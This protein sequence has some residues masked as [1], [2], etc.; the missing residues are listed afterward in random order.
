[1]TATEAQQALALLDRMDPARRSA[2]LRFMEFLLLEPAS[3]AAAAAPPD[4]ELVTEEDR[5]RLRNGH[6]WF[7]GRG[8]K[9]IPMEEVLAEFGLKVEDFPL[10]K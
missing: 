8:G 2:A 7:E 10:N 6:D 3:S 1:M 9:G 5:R 4:D